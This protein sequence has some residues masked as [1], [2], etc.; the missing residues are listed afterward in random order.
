[1]LQKLIRYRFLFEELVK[2]DFKKKY[3]R[4]VLGML[5]SIISPLMTLAVLAA[6]FSQFFGRETPHYVIYIF[7]GNLL[8]S[9]F[10]DATTGGMRSLMDNASI[11]TKV[12][13]PKYMFLLSRNVQ[14]FINFLLTL[15]VFFVFVAFEPGLPFRW[16]FL[17]LLYPIACI[18]IFNIGMGMILSALYVFF[19]DIEYLYSVFTMLLMYLSAIFYNISAYPLQIQ[20][21]FYA[22]PVYVYIR[23]FRKIVIENDIPEPSFHLL[24]ALYALIALGIGSWIYKKYNHK[25]LYYV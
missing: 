7:C 16:T 2:R 9:Y 5:W 1:M 23:Y 22:N 25:F 12:D 17:L 18:S 21:L 13:V 19:R 3:K 6:V 8:F 14:S 4:T 15:G 24:C 20:Y 10:S 11:F